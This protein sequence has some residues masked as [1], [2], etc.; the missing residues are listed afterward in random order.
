MDNNDDIET[1]VAKT[2]LSSVHL[3]V[4]KKPARGVCLLKLG[5]PPR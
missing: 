2:G 5:Q 3:N 4:V 1:V